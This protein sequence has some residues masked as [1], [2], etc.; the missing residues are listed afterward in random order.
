MSQTKWNVLYHYTSLQSFYRILSRGCIAL[1]D[2]IKSNDPAEGVYSLEMMKKAYIK[3]YSEETINEALY[4]FFHKVFFTFSEEET[5]FRRLQQAV[6]SISFCEP[7]I[8]LALWR[9]YGDNGCGVAIGFSKEKLNEIGTKAN[10]SFKKINYLSEREMLEKYSSFWQ[11]HKNDTEDNLKKAL[12]EQYLEGYFIKRPEN[13][14]EKEWRLVFTGL[15]L[16]E[17]TIISPEVPNELDA[18]VRK[19][20][21]VIYYNLSV[22]EEL[23]IDC[24]CIGPQ[25]RITNNEMRWLLSKYKIPF[26]SV[27]VDNTIMR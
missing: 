14:Y 15:N 10:F 2:I 17:Y 9:T 24:V 3:L 19:D 22:K 7:E 25:C 12:R 16:E 5:A 11:E 13:A 8:P 4:H 20:D 21:I 26:C 18:Y 23:P 1:N 27:I 6:L